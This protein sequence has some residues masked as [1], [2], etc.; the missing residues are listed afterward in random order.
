MKANSVVILIAALVA[1]FLI[2]ESVYIVK[3][4]ERAVKL[5]FGEIVNADIQPGLHIKMPFINT[6]R[7]FEA[8]IVTLDTRPQAF[9]TLE[10]KR[11]IVDAFIKWRIKNVETF[12]TATSGEEMRANNLLS[13][14]VETSLRNQFGERTLIQVV[15]GEREELM[16]TV[17]TALSQ[18]A[19]NDL[20]IEI[21]DVRIKRIELPSEVSTSVYERMRSERLRLARDLR[22]RGLELGEGIRANADRQQTV[23]IANAVRDSEIERGLGDAEAANIYAEAFGQNPEF[24]AFIRSLNAYR[25]AFSGNSGDILLIEPKGEFFRYLQSPLLQ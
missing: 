7:K 1:V 9:L 5:R 17:N 11:L 8:R 16:E 24:Y 6:I 19:E 14:R 10:A 13:S 3:E 18:V 25:A 21:I 15:S 4:T 23:I 20:G 22:A 12:Y 2:S